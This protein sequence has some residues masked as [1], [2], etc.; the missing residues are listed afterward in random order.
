MNKTMNQILLELG[1]TQDEIEQMNVTSVGAS[2]FQEGGIHDNL[3][4]SIHNGTVD[5]NIIGE[6]INNFTVYADPQRNMTTVATLAQNLPSYTA[7][8]RYIENLI[9]GVSF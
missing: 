2:A 4:V 7:A 6:G 8:C 1:H 9:N 5:F 3:A